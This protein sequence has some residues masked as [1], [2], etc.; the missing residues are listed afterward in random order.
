[1]E[2]VYKF[3]AYDT[4]GVRV[5]GITSREQPIAREQRKDGVDGVKYEREKKYKGCWRSDSTIAR[6]RSDSPTT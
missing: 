1:M 2:G 5:S 6:W 3:Q 4:R